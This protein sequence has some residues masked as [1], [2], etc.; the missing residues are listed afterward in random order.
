MSQQPTS[1][2]VEGDWSHATQVQKR[3]D[4]T[5]KF[6]A[7]NNGLASHWPI[8][9]QRL[10]FCIASRWYNRKNSHSRLRW[11]KLTKNTLEELTGLIGQVESSGVERAAPS[12]QRQPGNI[13]TRSKRLWCV[14]ATHVDI[15]SPVRCPFRKLQTWPRITVSG[16]GAAQ[17]DVANLK[18]N[19]RRFIGTKSPFV[20]LIRQNSL[21]ISRRNQV[22]WCSDCSYFHTVHLWKAE[23]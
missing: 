13:R 22:L 9:T 14:T 5:E 16:I 19:M 1:K 17:F 4:R 23:M 6:E 7:D 3:E 12:V 20:C 8:V 15:R 10:N 18:L 11:S 21:R 2:A